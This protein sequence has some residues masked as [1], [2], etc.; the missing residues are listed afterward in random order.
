M[1]VVAIDQGTSST[2]AFVLDQTGK[3]EITCTRQHRQI[4]PRPGW[5]EH[6]PEELLQHIIECLEAA[7]AVDAIGIDNQGESCLAWDAHSGR[8]ISPLIVWQD[9]RTEEAVEKLKADGAEELTLKRAGLPLDPYF[10]ASKLAWIVDNIPEARQ[11][12]N[13]RRLRLGT[14]DA[15]FIERL[16]GNFVTDITTASRTSLLNLE[17][18]QWDSELCDLFHIPIEALPEIKPSFG[19]EGDS[20]G[21]VKLK[22]KNVAITA[23]VVD[24]QAALY[25]HECRQPGDA[26]ITFGTGAFALVLTGD[27]MVRKPDQG[28]LPTIAWQRANA[29]PVYALDGAVYC[30][31]SALNWAKSLGL[32]A[33]FDEIN[34]FDAA[35]AIT[36]D[37][38]FVPALNGL[39]CPYWEGAAAGLWIGMGLDTSAHDMVQAIIEGVALRAGQVIDAMG[40]QVVIAESISIDG[41][42]SANPY[43]CQF[44]A[45]VLQKQIRVSAID[46]LTAMGTAMMAMGAGDQV[47]EGNAQYRIYEPEEQLAGSKARFAD[48][49]DRCRDW[50]S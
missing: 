13:K 11:L 15:F 28:L 48:A 30:A 44:L 16:T 27:V 42:M 35:P 19:G 20:F 6:D 25:G 38:A 18:G 12:L 47:D 49:V 2:R 17:T 37:L 26:K 22:G 46:E 23:S 43:F 36:R 21:T 4:Y 5:V 31:S 7:G 14:S 3:G 50:R 29:P 24:Q 1:R 39:A 40:A 9:R 33:S 45:T 8:A 34:A 10:S 32:F 41:G